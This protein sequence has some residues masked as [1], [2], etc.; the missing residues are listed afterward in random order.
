MAAPC[1]H[2]IAALLLLASPAAAQVPPSGFAPFPCP[3]STGGWTVT[4]PGPI[5]FASYDINSSLL[6]IGLQQ[7]IPPQPNTATTV[8]AIEGGS[9]PGEVLLIAHN[10]LLSLDDVFGTTPAKSFR[11]VQA[12]ANVPYGVM[13]GL[14]YTQNPMQ[15]YQNTVLS[16]PMLMLTEKDDCVLQWEFGRQPYAPIRTR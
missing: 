1:R 13:Q 6:Y 5:Y 16:Y 12:F 11:A 15:V 10:T 8:L 2:L 14:T 3:K 4:W 7:T 9:L